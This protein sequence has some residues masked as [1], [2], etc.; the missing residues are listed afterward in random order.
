MRFVGRNPPHFST[1]KHHS[2]GP[3]QPPLEVK[4]RA[5]SHD[6]EGKKVFI[7]EDGAL[8]YVLSH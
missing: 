6:C 4:I 2:Y 8:T 7:V 1:S 3:G 5:L